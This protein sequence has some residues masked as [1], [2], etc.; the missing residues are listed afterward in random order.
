MT[1]STPHITVLVCTFRRQHL[2]GQ[3]LKEL[4]RQQTESLF[5]YSVTI[6]DNDVL[7]SARETV[8][9]F[10]K[11]SSLD[12]TYCV[13]PEQNI[14]LA[15]NKALAN[16]T[17]DFLA[18]I[19]DDEFPANDWLLRLYET[20]KECKVD[21][22][23][24][25]VIPHFEAAPPAWITRGKF[26]DRP[27]HETGFT[28]DWTEGR[29]G[30]LLLKRDI[31]TDIEPVFRAEFGSGGEDRNLFR[32]LIGQ[33]RTFIWCNEAK[34]YESVPPVRL[35]R[36]FMLRRAL[37]RGKMSL[38]DIRGIRDLAKSCSAVIGYTLALPVFLLMGHHMFM[39]YLIKICDHAGKVLAFAGLEPIR[40]KYVME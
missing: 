34:V 28:I 32:R 1:D 26:C 25:P 30:N 10:Q 19:D 3:L 39:K 6:V 11:A 16:S 2:L 7:Q 36:G 18:F 29:T 12:I 37:L 13:E 21:G 20:C 4:D 15:R 27:S 35:K 31:L 14:A 17:G 9:Q 22:V 40:D 8:L 24:G 5:E 23:L 38:N 33:G